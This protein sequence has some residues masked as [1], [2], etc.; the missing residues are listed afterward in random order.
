MD[1]KENGR[2][3]PEIISSLSTGVMLLDFSNRRLLWQNRA[4]QALF[5]VPPS[6]YRSGED[7]LLSEFRS[8]N[9]GTSIQRAI[10]QSGRTIGFTVHF[11]ASDLGLVLAADIS[12]T[13]RQRRAGETATLMDALDYL[14][15]SLAHEI[16]NPINSIKMTLEVL[17]NNFGSYSRE[18]QLEYLG[19][20]HTEFSR[21]EELLRSIRSFNNFEYLTFQATD[22]QALIQNLLQMM[23]DDFGKSGTAITAS[24]PDKP[25]WV[26]CDPRA[27]HESL[28]HVIRNAI[29]ALEGIPEPALAIDISRDEVS[30]RIRITDNG[31]GFP[32]GKK[33]EVFLPFYSSKPHRAGLGLTMVK[34]LLTRMN[35]SVELN[36]RR[37]R[38]TEVLINLPL[39]SSY[40]N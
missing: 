4:M 14:F 11:A 12:E 10:E 37:P 34:K 22:V 32:E 29:E 23:R 17:I 26:T 31:C 27:L 38:G 35:G 39:V 33:G 5:A 1:D 9:Q 30:C 21:L 2:D 3:W 24:Y 13:A 18:T 25:I 15:F 36:P 28:L 8:G 20:L 16:G 40:G 19:S 6:G 7:F